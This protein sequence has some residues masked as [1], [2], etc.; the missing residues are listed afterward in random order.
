VAREALDASLCH[1]A[2]EPANFFDQFRSVVDAL[3][4]KH[5]PKT[6]TQS[7]EEHSER[8]PANPRRKANYYD[9]YRY[10]RDY[11]HNPSIF[12]LSAASAIPVTQEIG[13]RSAK[14]IICEIG[15]FSRKL[16]CRDQSFDTGSRTGLE[17]N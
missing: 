11:F 5:R 15:M 9:P 4:L 7:E 10:C 14:R 12:K 2:L 17:R 13:H 16:G 6:A 3:P 8:E 1:Q